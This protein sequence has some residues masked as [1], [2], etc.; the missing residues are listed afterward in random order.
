MIKL[1]FLY[2]GLDVLIAND[3][4]IDATLIEKR[5]YSCV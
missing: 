1:S 4:V 5:A 3:N 2:R